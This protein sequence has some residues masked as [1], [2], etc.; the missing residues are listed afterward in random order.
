MKI[1]DIFGDNRLPEVNKSRTACR[2]FIVQDGKI[3]LCHEI[4]DKQFFSPG[5]GIEKDETLE[6]C[7]IREL[8]EEAGYN[9]IPQKQFVIFNEYWLEKL[10]KQ[11]GDYNTEQ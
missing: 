10:A 2:G 6:E 8:R 5:G 11:G 3:L 1:V 7:C 9:V 4:V